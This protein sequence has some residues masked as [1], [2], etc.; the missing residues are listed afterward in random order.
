V[1]MMLRTG[2]VAGGPVTIVQFCRQP[3]IDQGL[4]ALVDGCQ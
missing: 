2:I 4:E 3:A 1:V